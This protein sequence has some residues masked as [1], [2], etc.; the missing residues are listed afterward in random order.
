MQPNHTLSTRFHEFK[1]VVCQPTRVLR[2]VVFVLRVIETDCAIQKNNGFKFAY[3]SQ[4]H[5]IVQLHNAVLHRAAKESFLDAHALH[6]LA[7]STLACLGNEIDH[8][9]W[10]LYCLSPQER[11]ACRQGLCE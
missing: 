3:C 7:E 6:P 4:K 2:C 5:W 11:P 9:D 1:E 8:V 10:F